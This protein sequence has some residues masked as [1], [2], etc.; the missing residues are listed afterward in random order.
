MRSPDEKVF[1]PAML[2]G[3]RT[4][5][6]NW[7]GRI[8]ISVLFGVLIISFAIWGIGN[9]FTGYGSNTAATVG[10]NEIDVDTLRRAYTDEIQRL[11]QQSRR[12]ITNDQARLFGIDRQVLDR[13]VS[14]AL[15]DDRARTLGLSVSE[16]T[17]AKALL[18]DPSLKTAD[19]RFNRDGFNEY[20][21]QNGYTEASFLHQQALV[22][23]RQEIIQGLGGGI[24]VPDVWLDAVNRYRN[25]QRSLAY[26]T[27]PAASIGEIATPDDAVLKTFFDGRKAQ[28]SAPEY[29]KV[30]LLAVSPRDFAGEVNVSDDELRKAYEDGAKAGRY[31]TPEK[32]TIQQ[33]TFRSDADAA[34]AAATP[35][36][37]LIG[38]RKLTD[39]DISLGAKTEAEIFDKAIAEAAFKLPEGGVSPPVKGQF[40]PVILRVTKIEP[41]VLTPLDSVK[42][43]LKAEIA[44]RKLATDA[45]V[46]EKLNAVHDKIEDLRASGK[47]LQE[48][49]AE[50]KLTP[51]LIDAVDAGGRDKAGNPITGLPDAAE[52]LRA[53][54]ASDVGVDN[55][56]IRTRDNGYLWFEI[57]AVDHAHEQGFDEVKA[58]VT[59]DWKDDELAKRLA[60][61]TSD[62]VKTLRGG[63][64][65]D[66]AAAQAGGAVEHAE[67]LTR[68]NAGA[69][70]QGAGTAAFAAKL[71]DFGDSLAANGHDRLVF[72]L[73]GITVPARVTAMDDPVRRQL[74]TALADD[75]LTQYVAKLRA[76]IGVTVNERAF[77]LATGG[78]TEN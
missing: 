32:R 47:G 39:A 62:M 52:T 4:A 73:T 18:D 22:T 41:A 12:A 14:D 60:A 5:A 33:I 77:R 37:Q 25:E 65:L 3:M 34:A 8:V 28:Y 69:V 29:R 56:A 68:A 72:Q 45:A 71:N 75:I 63:G 70:G 20:L 1:A 66:A 10:R 6:S 16:Q 19:G 76:E 30:A 58:K 55:D 44:S 38:E 53:I 54:Y 64:T 31:G 21:R 48:V 67:G 46:G 11:S 26:L 78:T 2:S 27:V 43:A 17:V 61:K 13:L 57:G 7:L 9:V 24:T 40:G 36:D 74:E 49:A 35:F 50:L 51:R 59:A 23:T 42:D 15:L